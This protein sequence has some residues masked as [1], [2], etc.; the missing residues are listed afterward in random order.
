MT[1]IYTT[2]VLL[3]LCFSAAEASPRQ[4]V[5]RGP[6]PATV[7][8]VI[9]GDTVAVKAHVWIGE[10]V[11]TS[12]RID[13]IDAPEIKG[14]C[15]QER[16]AAET[17]RQEVIRLLSNGN[18]RIYNIRLEKYAGRVLAQIR[19]ADGINIGEHMLE[20]GLA[21][22]YHGEKRQSWCHAG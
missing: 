19:T 14:K 11:E 22:P 5:I 15:T 4:E 7:L 6:V 13:G 20:K 2:I 8:R 1:R 3:L 16:V 18:V 17:A 12:I 10:E 21:R 9:D